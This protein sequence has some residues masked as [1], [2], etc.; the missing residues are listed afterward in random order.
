MV[1]QKIKIQFFKVSSQSSYYSAALDNDGEVTEI[2]PLFMRSEYIRNQMYSKCTQE[3][4]DVKLSVPYDKFDNNDDCATNPW[5]LPQD[6]NILIYFMRWP[7]TFVLWFTIPDCRR[8]GKIFVITFVNCVA[9]ILGL[10]YL[11]ASMIANVG[12][13]LFHIVCKVLK[14]SSNL[15]QF[16]ENFP[17]KIIL[18]G[19]FNVCALL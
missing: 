12:E 4:E 1:A 5:K 16:S 3:A 13:C 8:H 7:I 19:I 9:W 11:I 14:P 18:M 17:L 10:S 6:S 2:T 15:Y